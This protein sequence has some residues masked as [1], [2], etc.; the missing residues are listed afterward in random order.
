VVPGGE[1]VRLRLFVRAVG[2]RR[3]FEV[4]AGER[5]L[6]ECEV[7]VG[8]WQEI[9]SGVLPWPA[10]SPLVLR[11]PEDPAE[12]RGGVLVDRIEFEWLK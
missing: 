9:D 4:L 8:D 2:N 3:T 12:S 6:A 10:G 5:H 7:A 1:Q 11:N